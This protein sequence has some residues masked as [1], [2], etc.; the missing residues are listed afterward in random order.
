MKDRYNSRTFL[1]DGSRK[2]GDKKVIGHKFVT[3]MIY[4]VSRK[5]FLAMEQEICLHQPLRLMAIS[6]M[7]HVLSLVAHL[8]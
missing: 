2:C 7:F 6:V 1:V 4:L 3:V 5:E 8:R